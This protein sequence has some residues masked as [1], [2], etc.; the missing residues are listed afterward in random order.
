V[1]AT[2]YAKASQQKLIRQKIMEI[3]IKETTT[4]TLQQLFKKL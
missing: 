1:K 3:M 2:C 4:S